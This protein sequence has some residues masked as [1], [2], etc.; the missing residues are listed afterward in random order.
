MIWKTILL[1]STV[2]FGIFAHEVYMSNIAPT[3]RVLICALLFFSSVG[4]F[5]KFISQF[6]RLRKQDD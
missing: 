3:N 6:Q 4:Q 2:G 1:L 5:C